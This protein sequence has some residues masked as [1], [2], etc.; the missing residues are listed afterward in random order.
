M[1]P[2]PAERL[3]RALGSTFTLATLLNVGA[4]VALPIN[5]DA[6]ALDR[7]AEAATVASKIGTT[8]TLVYKPRPTCPRRTGRE[9]DVPARP[10]AGRRRDPRA[11][12]C[13]VL[14]IARHPYY[15]WLACPVTDAEFDEAHRANALFGAHLDDPE[16]GY[17]FLVDEAPDA[18][19]AM[20]DRTAWRI[21]SDN[22]W[23]TAFGKPKRGKGKKPS[24]RSTTIYAP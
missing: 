2:S 7:Y 23:W 4:T 6:T 11:V 14:K 19:V 8:W 12:T 21:C 9:N 5:D 16:F 18:G 1:P 3:A 10:R 22:G 24:P 17:R 15:R 13:R 20:A